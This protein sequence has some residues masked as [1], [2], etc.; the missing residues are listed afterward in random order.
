MRQSPFLAEFYLSVANEIIVPMFHEVC[1]IAIV[2]HIFIKV[3]NKKILY[4]KYVLFLTTSHRKVA[5]MFL[6][7]FLGSQL[8]IEFIVFSF[9]TYYI[10]IWHC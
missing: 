5:I 7:I 8:Q 4:W 9:Q 3:S 1:D 2:L 6:K 10:F